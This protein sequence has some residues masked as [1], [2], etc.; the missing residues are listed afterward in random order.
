MDVVTFHDKSRQY[1]LDK[2]DQDGRLLV[3]V[4]KLD[5]EIV[6]RAIHQNPLA[7][8]FAKTFTGNLEIGMEAVR[9]KGKALEFCS[10]D[11]KRRKDIV[12]EAV[13]QNGFA[14]EFA[15]TSLQANKDV[16]LAAVTQNGQALQFAS[17]RLKADRGV[18]MTAMRNTPF[19]IEKIPRHVMTKPFVIELVQMD[20][21]ILSLLHALQ[22]PFNSDKDVVLAAVNQTGEALRDASHDLQADKDVVLAAVNQTGEAL[23]YASRDLHADKDIV[24]AAVNQ[25]GEALRYASHD[26]QADK[27]VVLAAVNQNGEA[28]RYASPDLQTD[29][30][31]LSF[32][33]YSDQPI[34]LTPEQND[35]VESFLQESKATYESF[36]K[37]A[38]G[39]SIGNTRHSMKN[40]SN[41]GPY[42]RT[43]FLK[44]LYGF[45]GL[46]K[47]IQFILQKS[48]QVPD[49]GGRKRKTRRRGYTYS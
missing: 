7:L 40:L 13:H 24:L 3:Y 19:A 45:S 4:P 46:D 39:H 42:F 28:L 41:H 47:N 23:S 31:S 37:L 8:Q 25:T 2:M 30:L 36:K 16:V 34:E 9:Q 6:R 10:P 11:L 35:Q 22:Y 21:N 38:K 43:I 1:V 48:K 29:P 18:I 32:A 5:I 15:D 17:P 27:D 33:K 49:I 44:K 20:G 12:M 26:L 14:L